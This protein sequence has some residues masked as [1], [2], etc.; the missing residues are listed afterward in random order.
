MTVEWVAR[1]LHLWRSNAAAWVSF[2]HKLKLKTSPSQTA[3]VTTVTKAQGQTFPFWLAFT[4]KGC[5][6][7]VWMVSAKWLMR[8]TEDPL[9]WR[10][11]VHSNLR[12]RP[13][14]NALPNYQWVST[15]T[16]CAA[17]HHPTNLH[18]RCLTEENQSERMAHFMKG[19]IKNK[20]YTFKLKLP[21]I[22]LTHAL[23]KYRDWRWWW[24]YE[25]TVKGK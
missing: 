8:H 15:P 19:K 21:Q 12:F 10:R 2:A 6:E 7:S 16:T 13:Q 23:T 11:T 17:H 20:N 22:K 18:M 9:I 4:F 14:T 1:L 25:W 24:M 3:A 5:R